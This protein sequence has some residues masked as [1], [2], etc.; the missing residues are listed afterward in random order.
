MTID[1][2]KSWWENLA[3]REKKMVLVA[4]IFLAIFIFYTFLWSP[5]SS[6]VSQLKFH[7][8]ENRALLR[9]LEKASV[10]IDRYQSEGVT[11]TVNPSTQNILLAVEETLSRHQLSSYL[12]QVQQPQK[13]Q[14][15]L[16]FN[17]V[18]LDQWM[19]WLQECLSTQEM[20]IVSMQV[21]RSATPGGAV[22]S[23]V[24]MR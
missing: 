16:V 19:G 17:N 3:E 4:G 22:I 23:L 8:N 2:I 14:I 24:L 18:P 6:S 9:Y 7:V 12:K 1:F 13:N 20:V 5:L 21:T 15:Q 10:K 11:A